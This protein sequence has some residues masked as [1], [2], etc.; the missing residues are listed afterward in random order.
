MRALAR[1][2]QMSPR[3]YLKPTAMMEV[4]STSIMA[5]EAAVKAVP[6]R[7]HREVSNMQPACVDCGS[8]WFPQTDHREPRWAGGS[9]A[10]ENLETRCGPCNRAKYRRESNIRR[11]FADRS[12]LRTADQHCAERSLP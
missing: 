7:V 1:D 10:R 12:V 9:S 2:L 4:E 3:K 8:L 6:E 11:V 5:A